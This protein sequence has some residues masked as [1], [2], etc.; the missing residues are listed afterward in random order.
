MIG[1]SGSSSFIKIHIIIKNG[2][3]SI[4][5]IIL[6]K[7]SII[8]FI[9]L[10]QASRG[11]FFISITGILFKREIVVFVFVTSKVFVIYLYLIQ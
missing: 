11:V 6:Q 10:P 4:I 8:L 9:T 7:I 5:P 2:K 1:Q 3:S